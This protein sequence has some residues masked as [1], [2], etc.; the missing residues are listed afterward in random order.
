MR[1]EY[2]GSEPINYFT[3]TWVVP[4]AP[5]SDD[6]Q[7]VY[8]FNGLQPST[9]TTWILQPVLQWG[10]SA[11]GG[12]A[13][14]AIGN[15]YVPPNGSGLTAHQTSLIRVSPG[16]V[17]QGVMVLTAQSGSEFSYQSKFSG[18]SS[19]DLTVTDIPVLTQAFE[20]LECYGATKDSTTQTFPLTSCA[21][22]PATVVTAMR[23]IQI[24]T[25]AAGATGTDAEIQWTPQ[26]RFADCGQN[27]VI[28]SN[29]S[30]G[31][32]VYLY[33]SQPTQNFYF[34]NDKSSFGK[35]EVSDQIAKAGGVFTAAV[36]LAL[37]GFTLQQLRIDQPQMATPSVSGPFSTLSGVSVYPSTTDQPSY[38]PTNLYTPQRFLFAFDVKFTTEALTNNDF[39]TSGVSQAL[40]DATIT[41][42]SLSEPNPQKLATET[43]LELAAG[44]D[45]YFSN[46]DA[47]LG[48]ARH[49]AR[50]MERRESRG[51]TR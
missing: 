49:R 31:G 7:T 45:P 3:T 21:D 50:G 4:P 27:C 28:V 26:V 12:G 47:L 16:D 14:W 9:G 43:L 40:L 38:D 11:E 34:V 36:Y 35:D 13:Y 23:D 37:D 46:V 32:A 2:Q 41:I 5:S 51:S 30:P 25:G 20:T 42:G 24:T 6:G 29:D 22:Y 8:L 1:G 48:A 18:H 39:P 33:Y 10:P 44:A 17:L 15:W 19:I